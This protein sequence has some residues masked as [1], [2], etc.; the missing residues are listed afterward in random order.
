MKAFVTGGTGF[1]GKRLVLQ[2]LDRGDKV[3]ALV[4]SPEKAAALA[5]AGAHLVKGDINDR[6]AMRSAMQG[7]DVVFH[8]AGW[9]KLG[10][11]DQKQAERVNVQGTRSVLELAYEL[12][13]PRI[14]YVSTIAVLGDS[15]A[16]HGQVDES[17]RRPA[18]DPFL[19]E[20]DRTKTMAHYEVA[21][22]LIEKGAPII[23][24]MPGVVYG[25]GDPSLI[26]QL[27][28]AYY[29]GL[30]PLFPG[31]DTIQSYAYVDDIAQGII[32][33][34][35][36]GRPGES[37]VLTGP[38]IPF[39]ELVPLWAR[40]TGKP[41]PVAYIPAALLSPLTPGVDLIGSVLPLPGMFSADGIR[42]LD[43]TTVARAD[44]VRRELG[45]Q[46]RP[47]EEGMSL[48]FAAIAAARAQK[49]PLAQRRTARQKRAAGLL[50]LGVVFTVGLMWLLERRRK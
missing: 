19:S 22:P 6:E 37:Y 27:M 41:E 4:R 2:L 47:L 26:G 25:P 10:D 43:K 33:A 35:E 5:E 36:K 44:K 32:L 7:S 17:Y 42:V 48:T 3:Y 39:R 46:P 9:Y 15:R 34:A 45:W 29:I 23:I 49:K 40:L 20:Y 21:L 31:P 13:V 11:R 1:I 30:L 50:A 16:L 12:G 28:E 14:L 8:V 18:D 38:A 24:V